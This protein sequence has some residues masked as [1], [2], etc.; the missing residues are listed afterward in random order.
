[1]LTQRSSQRSYAV[2]DDM[3]AATRV[4]TRLFPCHGVHGYSFYHEGFFTVQTMHRE[5]WFGLG[6]SQLANTF[7]CLQTC[8]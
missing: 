1:M 2:Y 8:I 5:V 3:Y 6:Q 7:L 4:R